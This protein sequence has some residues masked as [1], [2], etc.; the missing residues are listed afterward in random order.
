MNAKVR[1]PA[2]TVSATVDPTVVLSTCYR[3]DGYY[4][5]DYASGTDY[6]GAEPYGAGLLLG[7]YQDRSHHL[8]FVDRLLP[9]SPVT[10][11]FT[12]GGQVLATCLVNPSQQP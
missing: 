1:T 10:R 3:L 2:P 12:Y 4:V 5:V 6:S 11:S 8:K 9:S 7:T